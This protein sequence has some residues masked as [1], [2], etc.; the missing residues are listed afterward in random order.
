MVRDMSREIILPI[1]VCPAVP[2]LINPRKWSTERTRTIQN[3]SAVG[4][5]DL[6]SIQALEEE[7]MELQEYNARVESEM[8]QLRTD[9][10][11]MELPQRL[12]G[13]EN[14]SFTAQKT[15]HLS[16]YYESLRTNFINLLDRLPNFDEKP[17]P[18]NF[19]IY[20]NRLQS[21]C[22]DNS[23]EDDGNTSFSTVKQA[24]QEFSAPVQQASN[25]VRS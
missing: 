13:H 1:E 23:R 10:T 7:I 4:A 9:I 16:E 2:E 15:R 24:M 5:E 12:L 20:L 3:P 11:Q 21:L 6:S 25:W 17:T 18:D 14:P 19:D 8:Y 22:A